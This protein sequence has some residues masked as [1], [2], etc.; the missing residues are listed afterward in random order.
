M[1][2]QLLKPEIAEIIESRNFTAL[3][4]ILIGWNPPDIADI[5]HDLTPEE[6]STARSCRRRL[7][8]S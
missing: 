5:L 7:R 8:V 3:R 2:G 1:L 6:N 4:E